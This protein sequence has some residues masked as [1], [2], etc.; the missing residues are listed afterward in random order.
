[1]LSTLNDNDLDEHRKELKGK[2]G[3]KGIRAIKR[4][5]VIPMPNVQRDF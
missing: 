3:E 1:M 4:L 2:L 5:S